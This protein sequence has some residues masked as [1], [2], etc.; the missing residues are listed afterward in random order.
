M[1]TPICTERQR[2]RP[3]AQRTPVSVAAEGRR[4]DAGVAPSLCAGPPPTSARFWHSSPRPLGGAGEPG[5][6]NCYPEMP[7]PRLGP[8]GIKFVPRGL[9]VVLPPNPAL[10]ASEVVFRAEIV[11]PSLRLLR[12]AQRRGHRRTP[13][14]GSR[15]APQEPDQ[16][17]TVRLQGGAVLVFRIGQCSSWQRCA[18]PLLNV[19]DK[20]YSCDD[21]RPAR[22]SRERA[23]PAM[24]WRRAWLT[25]DERPLRE[26][27]G[28]ARR[29]SH[30][31]R[32]GS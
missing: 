16:C 19:A 11:T 15:I 14:P 13:C 32:F 6:P 1:S 10:Q 2:A 5:S 17:P 30:E 26:H 23:S 4:L 8:A 12:T 28:G 3:A 29:R 27:P 20:K 7:A 22:A 21:D 25:G 31:T 18:R 24:R 9:F